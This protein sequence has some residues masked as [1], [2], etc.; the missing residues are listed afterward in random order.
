MFRTQTSSNALYL[1]KLLPFLA[2]FLILVFSVFYRH[3]VLFCALF[4]ANKSY[5]PY[6]CFLVNRCSASVYGI[7][8]CASL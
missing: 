5:M 2:C 8:F 6:A 4:V 1:F 3:F 7:L